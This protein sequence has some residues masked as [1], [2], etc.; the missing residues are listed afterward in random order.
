MNYENI[1]ENIHDVMIIG[2]GPA[3]L[4][5]ALL[6]G[7]CM[8]K[9]LLFDS[10]EARTWAGVSTRGF[11]G[12][13]GTNPMKCLE[14]GRMQLDRFE[15]V[16]H[17]RTTIVDIEREGFVFSVHE[18]GGEIHRGK[19]ILLASDYDPELPPIF[20]AD[21]FYGTSLHQCPNWDAWEHQ[22]KKIGVLG[23][24]HV[25]VNLTRK[26]ALWSSQI[27]LFTNG[28]SITEGAVAR[29]LNQDGVSVNS[30]PIMALEGEGDQL[31]WLRMEDGSTCDCDALFF[32]STHKFDPWLG[33]R[34]GY[35][36]KRLGESMD[37][38]SVRSTGV[39]G[40]FVAGNPLN[41]TEFAVVAAADGVKAAE[42]VNNWLF[43]AA[44]SYLALQPV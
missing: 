38:H 2:G 8:R 36:L 31:K 5:A 32:S 18:A 19:A 1:D 28:A 3:G 16:T 43:D 39:E 22:G 15:N 42:A 37:W 27:T 21:R 12:Y 4:S 30:A 6:L 24:D 14:T 20:G 26:L 25:A 40:L 23:A 34:L 10:G 35:Y 17:L 9:V 44:Q 33:T 7:R 29:Q 13:D 41:P 11:I